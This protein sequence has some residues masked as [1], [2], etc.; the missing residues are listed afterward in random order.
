MAIDPYYG[1]IVLAESYDTHCDDPRGSQ[2]LLKTLQQLPIGF[3]I[4][5]SSQN[6]A[7]LHLSKDV[8]NYFKQMGSRAIEGIYFRNSWAFLGRKLNLYLQSKEMNKSYYNV[9]IERKFKMKDMKMEDA[10]IPVRFTEPKLTQ[11]KVE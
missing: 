5:A 2:A 10:K 7:T 1:S 9:A 4:A 8:K 6:E 3:I 11:V